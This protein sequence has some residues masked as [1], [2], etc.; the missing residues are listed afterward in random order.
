MSATIRTANKSKLFSKLLLVGYKNVPGAPLLHLALTFDE[1]TDDVHGVARVTQ[2]IPYLFRPFPVRGHYHHTGLGMDK[3]LVGLTGEGVV[4]VPPPAI[5]T[6]IWPFKC[7]MA[8]NPKD[9]GGKGSFQFGPIDV[10]DAPVD[11]ISKAEIDV[12]ELEAAK[13]AAE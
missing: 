12:I 3:I 9:W 4:S 1:Q 13:A 6:A 2:P 7:T 5:G 11:C 10:K 8:L